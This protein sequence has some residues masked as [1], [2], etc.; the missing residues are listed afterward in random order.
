VFA[1]ARKFATLIYRPPPWGQP[2]V[3]ESAEAFQE[4]YQAIRI[5]ALRAKA[6]EPGLE[7]VQSA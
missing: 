7:S 5:T 1:T 6:K 3:G 4:C 2:Y